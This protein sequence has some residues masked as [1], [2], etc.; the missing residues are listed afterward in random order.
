M[1]KRLLSVGA[2][3]GGLAVAIGAFGAHG[4]KRLTSDPEILSAFETG[5]EYQM[6]HSFALLITGLLAQGNPNRWL[7]WAGTM[8]ITGIVFFSGSLYVI[9]FLRV[10]ESDAVKYIGP[11]TP[12]GGILF[13]AG[14]MFLLAAVAKKTGLER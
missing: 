5:V 10:Q 9:T 11:L 6:Y 14:W 2:I 12:L 13:I 7:R 1:H 3:F 8:F 4:L